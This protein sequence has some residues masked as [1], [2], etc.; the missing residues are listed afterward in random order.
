MEPAVSYILPVYNGGKFLRKAIQS[1]LGQTFPDLVLIIID[2]CSTDNSSEI[3][4]SFNDHRIL[5]HKHERNKGVVAAMN[6]GLSLV[7]TPYVAVMHADDI[8]LPDRTSLQ[9]EWLDKHPDTAVI[10]GKIKFINSNDEETG[11]W[12]LDQEKVSRQAIK[13][14][15][16]FENCIAHSSVMMRTAITKSYGYETAHQNYG[17]AVEDYPLWLNILSDGYWIDKLQN[18]VLLYR[19]HPAS[20]TGMYLRKNNPFW[21]NYY[22]KKTYLEQRKKNARLTNYDRLINVTMYLDYIKAKLKEIKAKL[23]K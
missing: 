18:D 2:D 12:P 4:Q 9:K 15:M 3:I 17:F 11:V 20:A 22:T 13:N 23:I 1:V 14:A 8:C 6:T 19:T 10:A 5:Y 7:Q 16:I 21:I